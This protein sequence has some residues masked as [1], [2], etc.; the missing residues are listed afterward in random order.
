LWKDIK[1]IG[2]FPIPGGY[3]VSLLQW[4]ATTF[5]PLPQDKVRCG[6]LGVDRLHIFASHTGTLRVTS[7][8]K[9]RGMNGIYEQSNQ[10]SGGNDV[11]LDHT[12]AIP[13]PKIS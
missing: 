1:E 5:I 2:S 8:F 4:A 13:K 10:S 9:G 3:V 12:R 11:S 6:N 7:P